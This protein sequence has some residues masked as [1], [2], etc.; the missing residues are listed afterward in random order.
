M[1]W[2]FKVICVENVK[3][4]VKGGIYT[5]GLQKQNLGRVFEK[6]SSGRTHIEK[7]PDGEDLEYKILEYDGDDKWFYSKYFVKIDEWREMQL[8]NIGI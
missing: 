5:V 6:P 4:L 8:N 3:T 1:S 2:E 7:I